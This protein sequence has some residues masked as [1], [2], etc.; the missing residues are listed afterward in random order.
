[1]SDNS[2]QNDPQ[3]KDILGSIRRIISEDNAQ[4]AAAVGEDEEILDLTDEVAADEAGD[5][6]EL[7]AAGLD[8]QHFPSDG[9]GHC[10]IHA[11]RRG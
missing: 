1:M 11:R 4:P 6:R 7:S 5:R 3:M 10:V 2:G 9:E 8:V